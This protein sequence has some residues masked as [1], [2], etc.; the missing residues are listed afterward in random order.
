MISSSAVNSTQSIKVVGYDPGKIHPGL[1]LITFEE[2]KI[3][4]IKTYEP[5]SLE[6][7]MKLLEQFHPHII[8]VESIFQK[9][10]ANQVGWMEVL[11]IVHKSY[12]HLSPPVGTIMKGL[13]I[14]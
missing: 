10:Y 7:T 5:S 14:P 1:S 3:T 2:L 8:S 4:S 9:L 12:L 6:C 13:D 11:A